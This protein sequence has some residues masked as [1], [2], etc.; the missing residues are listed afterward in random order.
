MDI[1]LQQYKMLSWNVRGLNNGVKQDDV[2][3]SISSY[4]RDIVCL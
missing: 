3:H 2:R 1:V 4:R